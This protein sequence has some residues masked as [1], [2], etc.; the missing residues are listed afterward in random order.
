MQKVNFAYVLR[1]IYLYML[2]CFE[3]TSATVSEDIPFASLTFLSSLTD[4][5]SATFTF[6][7]LVLRICAVVPLRY[8]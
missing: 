5:S 8:N 2:P 1:Y 3:R 6:K 4:N 7:A